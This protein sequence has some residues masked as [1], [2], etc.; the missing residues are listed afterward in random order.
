MYM[1]EIEEKLN[2]LIFE[3][4]TANADFKNYNSFNLEDISVRITDLCNAATSLPNGGAID[5]KPLLE[6]LRDDLTKLSKNIQQANEDQSK[7]IKL[8]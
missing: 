7:N 8:N 5:V 3:V 2:N 4:K 1:E 6:I